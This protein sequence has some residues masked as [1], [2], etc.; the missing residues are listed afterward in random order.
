MATP[1]SF[2]TIVREMIASVRRALPEA[3][4]IP[5]SVIRETVVNTPAS[6]LTLLSSDLVLISDAQTVGRAT[7]TDLDRL[8][9][10]FGL[11]RLGGTK[12]TGTVELELLGLEEGVDML[13]AMPRRKFDAG[14]FSKSA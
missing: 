8:A 14:R 4:T 10:N 11:S 6:Q 13:K 1:R 5:G 7:G 9:A 2:E 12:A 3:N